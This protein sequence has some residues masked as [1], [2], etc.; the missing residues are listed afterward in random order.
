M[1][2]SINK[3]VLRKDD[4]EIIRSYLRNTQFKHFQD[5]KSV[6]DLYMELRKAK[7]VEPEHFP[8]DTVRINSKI[9]VR[10]EKDDNV[11]EFMIVVPDKANLKER[12]ISFIAPIATAVIG[13]RQGQKVRWQVPSGLR[14]FTIMEVNND[15]GDIS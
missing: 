5:K 6:D 1:R 8:N 3:P 14:T 4:Y 7:L 13:F 2:Q 9:K 11:I 15:H 10:S 12:K